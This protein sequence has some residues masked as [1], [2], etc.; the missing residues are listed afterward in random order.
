MAS[1]PYLPVAS[2]TD[3]SAPTAQA[4]PAVEVRGAS[5]MVLVA[6]VLALAVIGLFAVYAG[7]ALAGY[8]S[9]AGNDMAELSDQIEGIVGGL[10]AMFVA[11]RIDYRLWGRLRLPLLGVALF[12]VAL[13]LFSGDAG[14]AKGSSRWLDIG[15]VRFQ[16]SELL[17]V[18]A[19]VYFAAN[20]AQ[21]SNQL[22]GLLEFGGNL[23]VGLVIGGLLMMQPDLGSTAMLTFLMLLLLFVGG[24][25]WRHLLGL[26]AIGLA[27]LASALFRSEYGYRARRFAAWL[28]PFHDVSADGYQLVSS[29]VAL[30]S[31]GE[32]GVGFGHGRAWLG[33]VPELHNDFVAAGIA[34]EFGAL[35]IGVLL[36]LFLLLMWRGM[37]IADRA[38]DRFGYLLAVG[39]TVLLVVQAGFNLA[40]VTGLV[41]TKGITLP[42][43]SSGKT[44]LL[45]SFGIIGMLLNISQNNPDMLRRAIEEREAQR[46]EKLRRLK[47]QRVAAHRRQN[48][49]RFTGQHHVPR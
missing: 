25:R 28:D 36:A 9:G 35:G 2:P 34:E 27:L 1:I 42:F 12:L 11:S 4:A 14:T 33:Y 8:H 24:A 39:L 48:T 46:I 26:G 16:P 45:V 7:S 29:F 18:A 49:A 23:A 22:H 3:T 44:S 6:V 15:L 43:V 40:V 21:K 13:T 30:A 5:D 20:I 10:I 17:K 38:R 19:V 37:L 41:P 47:V 31:G 32:S